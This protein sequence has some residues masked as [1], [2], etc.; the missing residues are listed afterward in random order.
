MSSFLCIKLPVP[1]T[2]TVQVSQV[3]CKFQHQHVP[4]EEEV[5]LLLD[6]IGNPGDLRILYGAREEHALQSNAECLQH[7]HLSPNSDPIGL[8]HHARL[9]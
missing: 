7:I 5:V 8:L 9:P 4:R 1:L 3:S 6:S 2:N